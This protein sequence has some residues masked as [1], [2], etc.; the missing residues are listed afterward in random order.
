MFLVPGIFIVALQY[1]DTISISVMLS[2][3]LIPKSLDDCLLELV[4]IILGTN[5]S[6]CLISA[7]LFFFLSTN[8]Y[9]SEKT[10]GRKG[11]GESCLQSLPFSPLSLVRKLGMN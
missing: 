4:L 10:P 3:S 1:S 5:L 11:C 2:Y 7:R 6:I 9:H 8:K